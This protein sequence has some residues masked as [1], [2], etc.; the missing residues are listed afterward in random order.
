MIT[1]S[2]Q[3][4]PSSCLPF[5]VKVVIKSLITEVTSAS[6]TFAFPIHDTKYKSCDGDFRR[7]IQCGDRILGTSYNE[8]VEKTKT[9]QIIR[10]LLV[11]YS[12]ELTGL[13]YVCVMFKTINSL[14]HHFRNIQFSYFH[15][16]NPS[17]WPV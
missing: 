14:S 6:L 2:K 15:T 9:P 4:T 17:K 12:T 5:V 3:Q 16:T 13:V 1:N 8:P 10:A 11:L 7:G